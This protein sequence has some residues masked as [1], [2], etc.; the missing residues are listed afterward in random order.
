MLDSYKLVFISFSSLIIFLITIFILRKS[1]KLN[2]YFVLLASLL[3]LVSLLKRGVHQS[4]DFAINIS[5][6]MDMWNSVTHGIFPVHWAALLNATYG[7]PLFL[8]TY[9]L[10]Y[11]SIVL[12]KFLGFSFIASEKIVIAIAFIGSGLAMYLLLRLFFKPIHST[13]GSILYLFAPYHLVDMHF[14][15]ALGELFAY[16]FLPLVFYSLI[17]ALKKPTK[18]HVALSS[19]SFCLLILS[20]QAISLVTFPFILILPF[21]LS[22]NKDKFLY[23]YGSVSLALLMSS[24]Y[25]LPVVEGINHT[26][27]STFSKEVS[28]EN[29]ILYFVSPWRGGFLYQGPIGQISFP[30]GFVQIGLAFFSVI[31]LSKRGIRKS[32]RKPLILLLLILLAL[33]LLLFPLSVGIWKIIPFMTNF[34]FAYRLML[35]ISF[36][37]A[38]IG[39]IAST[40]IKLNWLIYALIFTAMTSTILNWGTRAML[41][42]IT[43]D[44]L[45]S[46]V[47]YATGEG[48]GLQ[49]AVPRARD[50][51]NMWEKAPPSFPITTGN[52]QVVI[53][54]IKRT[55]IEHV[56][57]IRVDKP[58]SFTEHT[59]YFPG[60]KLYVN[61]KVH[62]INW[63]DKNK[64]NHIRFNLDKG[65][66]E[67]KLRFENTLVVNIANLL[68]LL[69]LIL[70]VFYLLTPQ[71]RK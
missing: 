44:N 30:M 47:P 42:D 63:I 13:L 22:G 67:V 51:Q 1:K 45:L 31:L 26:L 38:I 24:F 57:R 37:L 16:L 6:S 3:P 4:G 43:D 11:Y 49:P 18:W 54:T 8:F 53:S 39:T 14:R 71:R 33:V 55:P 34:Q 23:A 20:H 5:K 62:A 70:L 60:W 15:V 69:G 58:T 27:Q 32:Y 61:D 21:L 25:W 68:S 52:G 50:P 56:Y 19:V 7:Y 10:P 35:P 28:F 46:R 36:V 40:R 66:Y 59:Y 64:T 29:P 2:F 9:P 65:V 48:E 41:S 17:K 12:F